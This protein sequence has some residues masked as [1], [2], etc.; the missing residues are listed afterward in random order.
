MRDA[1][2]NM[3]GASARTRQRIDASDRNPGP[4]LVAGKLGLG[5][6]ALPGTVGSCECG[7]IG[8]QRFLAEGSRLG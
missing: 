4:P 8:K 3:E 5:G 7:L 2:L 1:G 6:I